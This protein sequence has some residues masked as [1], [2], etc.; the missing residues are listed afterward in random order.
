MINDRFGRRWTIFFG[1]WCMIFGAMLQGL[2]N[3]CKLSVQLFSAE[4]IF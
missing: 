3:G 2:S 1:S 4:S